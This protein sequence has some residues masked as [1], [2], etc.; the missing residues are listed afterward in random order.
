MSTDTL[1]DE[2]ISLPVEDRALIVESLLSSLN[3][4]KTYIDEKWSEIA[5][6][7]LADIRSGKVKPIDG[8]YVFDKI[9]SKF[10][11]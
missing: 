3:Q 9:W 4:P 10:E 7:R 2:A 6:K 11:K 8:K 1:I 5:N